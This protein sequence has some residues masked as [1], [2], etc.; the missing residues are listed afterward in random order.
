MKK[1]ISTPVDTRPDGANSHA[2]MRPSQPPRE[3][4]FN[5]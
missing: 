3:P 1:E 4:S 5:A 2:D